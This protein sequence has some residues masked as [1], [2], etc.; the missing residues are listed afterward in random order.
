[1]RRLL[2]FVGLAVVIGAVAAGALVVRTWWRSAQD[3]QA[4]LL[5]AALQQP[6]APWSEEMR[7]ELGLPSYVYSKDEAMKY[8]LGGL[9]DKY[10]RE[11]SSN[12]YDIARYFLYS[13]CDQAIHYLRLFAE[14]RPV[15]T[16]L[17]GERDKRAD[18]VL[19]LAESQGCEVAGTW[20]R[21]QE[22]AEPPT[23]GETL[24][25]DLTPVEAGGRRDAVGGQEEPLQE[26]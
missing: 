11:L 21:Q 2:K 26:K 24:E 5:G 15:L 8:Y 6:D 18:H 16:G 3:R 19:N 7:R 20:L 14:R 10:P 25:P 13:D 9:A 12:L 22:G 4:A 1:M 23:A 17:L